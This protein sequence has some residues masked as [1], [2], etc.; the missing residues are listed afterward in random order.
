MHEGLE[1]NRIRRHLIIFSV[2]APLLALLT[3]FGLGQVGY[4]IR[5]SEFN[6]YTVLANFEYW[7]G[8]MEML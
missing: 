3:Y 4:L 2:S 5:S 7:L 6:P 1:R 8:Y